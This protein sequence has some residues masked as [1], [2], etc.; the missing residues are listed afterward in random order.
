[1]ARIQVLE[2]PMQ[3]VGDVSRTP[4]AIII[5]QATAESVTTY[6]GDVVVSEPAEFTQTEVDAIAERMGA[7]AAILTAATLDVA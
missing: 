4:F 5:D 7:Q 2:L 1:M 6:S 3:H